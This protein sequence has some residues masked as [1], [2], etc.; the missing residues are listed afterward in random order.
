MEQTSK[1]MLVKGNE[2]VRWWWWVGFGVKERNP[3]G[4][5]GVDF[6]KGMETAVVNTSFQKG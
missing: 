5:M 2:V 3:E 4:R 6:A 1:G